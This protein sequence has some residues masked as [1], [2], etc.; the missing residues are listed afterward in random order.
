M[1]DFAFVHLSGF[2]FSPYQS[3]HVECERILGNFFADSRRE[4]V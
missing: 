3:H 1:P 2:R 4:T